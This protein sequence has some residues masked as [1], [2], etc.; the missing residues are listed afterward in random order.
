MCNSCLHPDSHKQTVK[1]AV[2]EAR[3]C[4]RGLRVRWRSGI[5]SIVRCGNVMGVGDNVKGNKKKT[6][7]FS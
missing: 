1:D 4:E 6:P 5:V 7:P 2:R 3:R